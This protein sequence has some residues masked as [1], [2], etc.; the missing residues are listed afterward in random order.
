MRG[1]NMKQSADLRRLLESIDR[2]SYPAYKSAQGIYAFESYTLSIDHVQGD[3][4]ASPSKVS[5]TVPHAR[6]GYPGAYFDTPWKKTALEDYLVRQ[7]GREIA[8]F[9]FKA[10]G[11]GKSGLIAISSPGPEILSRTACEITKAGITAR[12]EV[13]FPAFGRTINSGELIKIL[14]EFLPRCVKSVFFHASRNPKEVK[15]VAELAEDQQFI[16]EELKRRSLVAFVAD[17]AVLPRESGVSSRPMKGGVAFSSPESLRV[18]MELPH[19][20]RITGMGIKEGITLI[21]GGGYHGKSTLL[22]AL[23]LGVYNHVAGDGREYVITDDTALKLRAEDGRSINNVDISLFIN[24]LP[25][26]KDTR[27]FSTPD[28]S[29]ST[30]QAAGVVEGWEAG[31]RVF[32]IDEDTSATNFMLRD[33]LMQHIISRD[34]EPITPFIERAR[35]LFVK[36]GISTV[37]VAGSSGAYFYI[38]DTIIQMDCYVPLDI[39][40]KTKKA[41][42]EYGE[43]PTK[44]APGFSL[45]APGRKLAVA[46]G[47]SMASSAGRQSAESRG[48]YVAADGDED[49]GFG[50]NGRGG[51]G[52]GGRGG[53]GDGGRGG[54]GRGGRDS[55]SDGG[56]DSYGRGGDRSGRGRDERIKTKT[57]GKDSLQVGKEQVDLRFVEQLIHGEQ[58]AALAQMV[59]Y[60]LE[61]QLFPRYSVTEIVRLLTSEI[62]RGGLPAISDSSYAAMGLCMPREQEIFACLNRYRG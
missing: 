59:R 28:A 40:E 41:C 22:K 3:P 26:K 16:R 19:R 45:P 36:A 52:S 48:G 1:E 6:A 47:K 23:E 35:D 4:F 5:I 31:S 61:K 13:G 12:F 15:A 39:T 24:D 62:N 43:D 42:A 60:C 8:Q 53:H 55:D 58:T 46:A 21:V 17:G 30:S 51:Y 44:A 7:F 14:F 32:L 10:K 56:R 49:E 33:E 34:K 37:L 50:G 54:Y 38:A 9:N 25:N 2:K 18:E 11:S 57:Y 27:R 20:G 29:G